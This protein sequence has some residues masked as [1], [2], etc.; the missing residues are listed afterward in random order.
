MI[1]YHTTWV[2]LCQ[3]VMCLGL[4]NTA[5]TPSVEA[6]TDYSSYYFPIESF[7]EGGMVYRYRNLRDPE[8]EPEVWR[9]IPRG[10]GLV[11]SINYG[12]GEEIA[13]R[14]FD[15]IVNNGVMTDSLLLYS[16][17]TTGRQREIKVKVISPHR[18]P[19]QP[20]DSTKV[21]LTHLDWYQPEDSLHIVLQRRRRFAGDTTWTSDGKTIP[22]V[23]FRTEDTFE[24]EEA[25]W[26]SST[27]S[28]EEIYAKGIGLV[29]YKRKISEEMVLEF[30]LVKRE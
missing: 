16:Q 8:A 15:K 11:E 12:S 23:R 6:P 10:P 25:G 30:E 1:R 5:C 7:P 27:W 24:T 17:D 14:Q 4:I 13:L 22:A 29:Y 18:F 28:G 26:T 3:I 20:G 2:I 19:F 9:H 21:W